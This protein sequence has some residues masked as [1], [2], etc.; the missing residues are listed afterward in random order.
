MT[1][2][3]LKQLKWH[4]TG[5]ATNDLAKEVELLINVGYQIESE[6]FSDPTQNIRGQFL[7]N[8]GFRIEVLETLVSPGPVDGFISKGIKYY[9]QGYLTNNFDEVL[10]EAKN[11]GMLMVSKPEHS[12]YFNSRISFWM[13]RHRQ[14]LEFI[15]VFE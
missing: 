11:N 1:N 7:L 6:I 4:H 8:N 12:V 13:N 14:L 5:L 10:I 15:E 2:H 9:H 3:Y